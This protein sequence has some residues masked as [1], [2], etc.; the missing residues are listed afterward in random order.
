MSRR[1]EYQEWNESQT[2]RDAFITDEAT[3][4]EKAIE[5]NLEEGRAKSLALT[6]LEECM[7]WARKGLRNTS[8]PEPTPVPSPGRSRT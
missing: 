8:R 3:R 6:K 5:E 7:M 2:M 4:L 1:F